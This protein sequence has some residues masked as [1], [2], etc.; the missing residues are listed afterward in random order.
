MGR[1]TA[2]FDEIGRDDVAAA[3][4]K[5][6][7][8][9][10]MI[11]A[12]LPV[13]PGFVVTVDAYRRF[14]EESGLARELD[15]AL[16]QV[17][18][19]D[20]AALDRAAA[21]LQRRVREASIPGDVAGAVAEAYRGFADRGTPEPWV[22]VRSSATVEDAAQ[23]SFAGMFRT[24]LNVRG[25]EAL[26]D[27]VR[28]CWSSLFGAR[29]LFYRAK[30]NVGASEWLVAVAVQ[31][32]VNA[33]V[34][35]VMFTADP[36]T[37]DRSRIVIESAWGLGEVVVG[38]QVEVDHFA[39]AKEDLRILERRIGHKAFVLVRD[40]A[41]GGNRREDLPPEKADAPTLDDEQ[42]RALAELGKRD[43]AHY[44]APQDTEFAIEDGTIFLVQTRPITTLGG[45]RE[46]AQVEAAKRE[47]LV[48]GLGASPGSASGVVRI[49]Q[50]PREGARL[51][52]GEVLVAPM[53]APDW[54]PV[55]RRA[56]AI[57]TAS[58][59]MTSHAAIVSREMGVPCVVGARGALE[60]LRDGEEVTVDGSHGAIYRGRVEPRRQERTAPPP[61]ARAA[62][63]TATRLLVNLAGTARAAEIAAMEVEGIGLLR[64]EF[65]ILEALEGQHPR[66][67]LE[68]GEGRRF[69]DRLA[70]R[71]GQL[72]RA[73]HPRP[74]TYRSMDFRS[75]E[76]RGLEGG[77]RFEP[78]EENP[79][80]GYRGCFRYVHEP[81]LFRLELEMLEAVRAE[82]PNVHLMIPFVRT[83]WE[84]EACRRIVA[85]SGLGRDRRLQLWVMAEVP[86]VVYWIPAYA[87]A[88]VY[89]VSIGSNDLTQ[90]ML[91]VDRDSDVL[92]PLYDERDEAVVDA[93]RTIIARS[94]EHGLKA[95]ICGQA[96]SVHPEYA[97]MLV[98]AGIDSISV[99]PDSIESARR[100]IAA[101][102]Q[103]LLL[104]A[105]RRR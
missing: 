55:M 60:K 45:A 51:R 84:F 83:R 20:P 81:E 76:F 1:L 35:G 47:V 68:R 23:A 92:A 63:V 57:V 49:L 93:I 8:L 27:A 37:G 2:W 9:G 43:E 16:G 22:A 105:A 30:R 101:A 50:S 11:R 80:I 12:G 21:E 94:H 61:A 48:R 34:S 52:A 104:E 58:G 26:L 18:V 40:E 71:I 72:A 38:G 97:E 59:G 24:F 19:D 91:G 39:V 82:T 85:E 74:I 89:G 7:N 10:E 15:E 56:A 25:E 46:E 66:L 75:N 98:R 17:D 86:S 5:A 33:R 78:R 100:H 41:T 44:G 53:T 95:S 73:F 13:P 32:M 36:A 31:R 103:R 90:L 79:M 42:V 99:N 88:G 67:L 28:S 14:L 77:D 3:G 64:A 69:V 54:V 96:P 62:P 65:M 6:A 4:G 29:V 70:E 102:E 87:R